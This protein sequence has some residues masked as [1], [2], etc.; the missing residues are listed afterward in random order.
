[1]NNFTEESTAKALDALTNAVKEGYDLSV[2]AQSLHP[3][4][5]KSR[6]QYLDHLAFNTAAIMIMLDVLGV[7]TR[8]ASLSAAMAVAMAQNMD[9][10]SGPEDKESA[11]EQ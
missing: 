10:P 8:K 2:A 11:N 6:D 7:D 1:M 4:A 9:S 5:A 3:R